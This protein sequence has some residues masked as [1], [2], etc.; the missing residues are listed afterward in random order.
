MAP[1]DGNAIIR[2]F[3]NHLSEQNLYTQLTLDDHHYTMAANWIAQFNTPL[4]TLDGLH[5]ALTATAQL[6]LLTADTKL[7]EAALFF[8]VTAT[9]LS[10]SPV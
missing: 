2:Q 9:L 8:G 5:L 3:E 10:P 4:R 7:A 1:K 6:N